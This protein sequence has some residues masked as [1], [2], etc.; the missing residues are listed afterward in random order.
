M[1][2]LFKAVVKVATTPLAVATD[3]VNTLNGEESNHTENILKSAK[4]DVEETLE[5]LSE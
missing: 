1:F 2:G 3:V 4:K 5:K